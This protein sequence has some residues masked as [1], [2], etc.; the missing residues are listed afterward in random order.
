MVSWLSELRVA[1][2]EAV[3]VGVWMRST[4][5]VGGLVGVCVRGGG[6]DYCHHTHRHAL[7]GVHHP[8]KGQGESR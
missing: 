7:K 8:E 2:V 1:H 4:A 5:W 3:V 6:R